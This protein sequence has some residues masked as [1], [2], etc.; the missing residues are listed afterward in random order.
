[1]LPAWDGDG[2]WVVVGPDGAMLAVYEPFTGDLAKPS[3]VLAG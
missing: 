1:V 2:P 3:V